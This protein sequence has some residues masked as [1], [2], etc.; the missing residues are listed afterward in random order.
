VII[1]KNKWAGSMGENGPKVQGKIHVV[2]MLQIHNN[3]MDFFI[4]E[5]KIVNKKY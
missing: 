3:N 1:V 2:G 4:T 5:D